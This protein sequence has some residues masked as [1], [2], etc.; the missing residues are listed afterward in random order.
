MTLYPHVRE[1]TRAELMA[2]LSELATI[3]ATCH[4]ETEYCEHR[5]EWATFDG[6]MWL[7]GYKEDK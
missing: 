7:L 3:L 5:S 1:V 2:Q 6:V 4:S